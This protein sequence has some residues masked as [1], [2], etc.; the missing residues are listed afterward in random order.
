MS[1]MSTTVS[2]CARSNTEA[3]GSHKLRSVSVESNDWGRVVAAVDMAVLNS[4]WR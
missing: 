2:I 4:K 3:R 1:P